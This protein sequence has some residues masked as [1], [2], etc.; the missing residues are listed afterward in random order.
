MTWTL[1][2]VPLE[3]IETM[4]PTVAPMLARAVVYSGGRTSTGALFAAC[5]ASRGLLWVVYRQLDK[6]IRA[7][8]VTRVAAYPR[9]T[10]LVIDCAGGTHMKGW[11]KTVLDTFRRFAAESGY[12]GVEMY[13]RKGWR[14]V[15]ARCGW[16]EAFV[17]MEAQAAG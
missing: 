1:T 6:I 8:F 7:A 12:G 4:W 5:K 14:R 13:G 16:T 15:L 9:R 2:I 10:M 3:E 17:V 11:L